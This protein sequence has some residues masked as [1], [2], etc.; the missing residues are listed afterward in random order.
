MLQFSGDTVNTGNLDSTGTLV[1]AD[2][3]NVHSYDG[4]RPQ[5]MEGDGV[6]GF[7]PGQS[8]FGP[9]V[10]GVLIGPVRH[11]EDRLPSKAFVKVSKRIERKKRK[12]KSEKGYIKRNI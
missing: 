9:R 2:R 10:Q 12:S 5:K 8:G 7:V 3:L 4:P 1:E 11:Y 6:E